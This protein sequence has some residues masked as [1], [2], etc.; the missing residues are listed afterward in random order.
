MSR[1]LRGLVLCLYVVG[2]LLAGPS[3]SV[4]AA[5]RESI[6]YQDGSGKFYRVD[7]NGSGSMQLLNS[8][9]STAS[10]TRPTPDGLQLLSYL[11]LTGVALSSTGGVGAVNIAPVGFNV[12][13]PYAFSPDGTQIA[14]P[15]R[16]GG[17]TFSS[18]YKMNVD[19]TGP[20]QLVPTGARHQAVF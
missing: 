11:N 13:T 19:G 14:Y 5:V 3:A 12:G 7:P 17:A 16:T 2:L 9:G 4:S 15:G 18:V 1:V 10:Y 8:L 6:L 20:T